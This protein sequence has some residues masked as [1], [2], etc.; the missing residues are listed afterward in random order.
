MVDSGKPG[1]R[2]RFWLA[3]SAGLVVGQTALILL[4]NRTLTAWSVLAGSIAI[5]MTVL[6]LR[7]ARS[8]SG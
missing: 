6:L 3:L 1:R 4:G 7:R 5:F 2:L 8:R